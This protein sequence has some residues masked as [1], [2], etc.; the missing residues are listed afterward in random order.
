VATAASEEAALDLYDR[1]RNAGFAARI[2]PRATE[3]G[4]WTYELRLGGYANAAEA[5]TA[6]SIVQARTRLKP[7]GEP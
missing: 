5:E 3:G 2:L 4:D 1:I 6:A 7:I